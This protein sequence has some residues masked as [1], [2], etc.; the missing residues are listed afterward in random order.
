M[1]I[2]N[3]GTMYIGC[4]ELIEEVEVLPDVSEARPDKIYRNKSGELWIITEDGWVEFATNSRIE[5]VGRD[6]IT[7][8]DDKNDPK[9][10]V[11]TIEASDLTN[12]LKSLSDKVDELE[13]KIGEG[14]SGHAPAVITSKDNTLTV[15][16]SGED[17]QTFDIS[18]LELSDALRSSI[19]DAADRLETRIAKLEANSNAT[20]ETVDHLLG[21]EYNEIDGS[22]KVDKLGRIVTWRGV[23]TVATDM[24]PNLTVE[25]GGF[26]GTPN[27]KFFRPNRE[28]NFTITS[29]SGLYT[30]NVK[31]STDGDVVISTN[32][33]APKKG[34]KFNFF[35]SW[36]AV[37]PSEDQ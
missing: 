29:V 25:T 15:V 6:G 7:I 19:S 17:N 4:G 36:I 22:A 11:V 10:R 30:L 28:M 27:G 24:Q 12:A 3:C 35:G 20:L 32:S 1:Q 18:A 31:V 34:E 13:G 9:N 8:T 26:G 37:E 23:G 21:G 33:K 2:Q 16:A 5:F 14:G